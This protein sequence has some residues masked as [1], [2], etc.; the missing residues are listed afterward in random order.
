MFPDV[1]QLAA[2]VAAS[3]FTDAAIY[4]RLPDPLFINSE[5]G[6]AIADFDFPSDIGINGTVTVNTTGVLSTPNCVNPVSQSVRRSANVVTVSAQSAD[7]CNM[8]VLLDPTLSVSQYNVTNVPCPGSA[9]VM[10]VNLQPVMFWIYNNKS[11]GS[12]QVQTIFCTPSIQLFNVQV[13]GMLSE[14]R[15]GEITRTGG[16]VRTNNVTGGALQGRAYNSVVFP[17]NTNPVIQARAVATGSSVVGA[18]FRAAVQR[19]GG[20]QSVFDLPNGFL[21]LTSTVYRLHLSMSALS[22]YFVKQNTTMPG[23][24]KSS[25]TVLWIDPLPAHLLAFLLVLTGLT[26]IFVQVFHQR[27]RRKLLLAA[28]PGSI[29]SIMSLTSRSGFGEL[30]LPYDDEKTLERKLGGLK[31]RLDGRTGAIIADVSG[32]DPMRSGRDAAMASLLGN[33]RGIS[34]YSS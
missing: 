25:V 32:E 19:P 21:D 11:D 3:G 13:S 1:D 27:E 28:P 7:G 30:L 22:I 33:Y 9:A 31:F 26:G 5:L 6:W 15:L 29:A 16:T 14:R 24:V 2:F 23:A 10:P 8:T 34:G 18:I 20:P 4:N 17:R 12:P